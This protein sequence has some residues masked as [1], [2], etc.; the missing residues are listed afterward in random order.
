MPVRK[1]KSGRWHAEVCIDGQRLHRICPKGSGKKDAEK[2]EAELRRSLERVEYTEDPPLTSI[3]ALYMVHAETLRSSKTAMEHAA[4]LSPFIMGKKASEAQDAVTE[5]NAKLL[6]PLKPATLNRSIG[7]LKKALTLAW[8]NRM[9]R[10]NY[11]ERI[12]RHVENNQ[13]EVFLTVEQVKAIADKASENVRAAIWIAIY[14]G[15]R[16]GEILK[17][18]PEHISG[19]L[20]TIPAGNTKTLKMRSVPVIKPLIPWLEYIPLP[21]NFEGLKTGFRRAREEAG[22]PHVHFHDL[23]HSTASLLAHS[24]VDLLTI[25]KILGHSTTR[26]SERYAHIKA[27]K[28]KEALERVFGG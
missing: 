3:M 19:N 4:R 24:G 6:G 28:Q 7:T 8:E 13:R 23:R 1:D 2:L 17:L 21:I 14:T 27:D 25:S 12:K 9:I 16:R 26:M 10:E 15:M 11:G 20:I 18:K 22:M 5:M